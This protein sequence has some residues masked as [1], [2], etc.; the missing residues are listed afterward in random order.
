MEQIKKVDEQ[1]RD[2][3]I[4]NLSITRKLIMLLQSEAPKLNKNTSEVLE[5]VGNK[6]CINEVLDLAHSEAAEKLDVLEE[7]VKLS[8][9]LHDLNLEQY[10]S[11]LE[12]PEVPQEYSFKEVNDVL[13]HFKKLLAS[14]EAKGNILSYKLRELTDVAL[15]LEGYERAINGTLN[16]KLYKILVDYGTLAVKSKLLDAC[17]FP[18]EEVSNIRISKGEFT[19]TDD[20]T[21]KVYT[22][23]VEKS[24]GPGVKGYAHKVMSSISKWNQ[25]SS[26]ANN[27]GDTYDGER[28][29]DLV[30]GCDM[31]KA[32]TLMDF[33]LDDNG[34]FAPASGMLQVKAEVRKYDK[35]KQKE[36]RE[37][38]K[39]KALEAPKS[40]KTSKK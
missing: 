26:K 4:T 1:K 5:I 17:G 3:R 23:P 37:R 31:L 39:V 11:G 28:N 24:G 13:A 10:I 32:F 8:E 36:E 40:Q 27:T 20:R 9:T 35:A 18:A 14:R 19:F 6:S 30:S 29:A 33:Y 7:V 22:V 12:K 15:V 38:A 21:G 16:N 2:R 25:L 34:K